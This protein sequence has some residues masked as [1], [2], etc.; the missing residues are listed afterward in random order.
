MWAE[1]VF[2]VCFS[3]RGRVQ[4]YVMLVCARSM[5]SPR[6]PIFFYYVLILSVRVF[7][8]I[9]ARV[10]TLDHFGRMC[11]TKWRRCRI[12]LV[13]V[14]VRRRSVGA[15]VA[16]R[17]SCAPRGRVSGAVTWPLSVGLWVN[18]QSDSSCHLLAVMTMATSNAE[19][20]AAPEWNCLPAVYMFADVNDFGRINLRDLGG[21]TPGKNT[22]TGLHNTGNCY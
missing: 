4:E 20:P 7:F 11:T 18:L 3:V 19:I 16:V 8:L 17:S 10:L 22:V 6:W 14:C 2:Y 12:C 9:C 13:R 21:L 15:C 1:G 5:F